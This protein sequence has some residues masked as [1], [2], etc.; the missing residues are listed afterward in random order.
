M[1]EELNALRRGEI[2]VKSKTLQEE[3]EEEIF[4]IILIL[5]FR[6]TVG[7][8]VKHGRFQS[9]QPIARMGWQQ[10]HRVQLSQR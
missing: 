10:T 7:S 1:N 6:A 2:F 9:T 3:E 4:L 8:L 5:H